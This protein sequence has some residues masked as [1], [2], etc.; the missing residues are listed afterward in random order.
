MSLMEKNDYWLDQLLK[1]FGE[2][3]RKNHFG[4]DCLIIDNAIIGLILEGWFYLRGCLFARS[5]FESINLERLIFSKKGIPLELRYYRVS[6]QIWHNEELLMHCIDLAYR[7]ALE[8]KKIKLSM[9]TR[10]KDLPNMNM[11]VERA[12]GKIGIHKAED[13]R[14]IG[15]KACFLKLKQFGRFPPSIKLLIGLAGAIEGYHSA[16]LPTPIKQELINWYNSVG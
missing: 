12:L 3:K 13:L 10:I 15:A 1:R 14:E 16:V 7:S 8:E 9:V 6:E 11:S 2:I 4:G 5:Y